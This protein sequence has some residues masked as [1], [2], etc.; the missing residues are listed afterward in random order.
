MAHPICFLLDPDIEIFFLLV[1][2]AG[3][4]DTDEAVQVFQSVYEERGVPFYH[5]WILDGDYEREAAKSAV[6]QAIKKDITFTAVWCLSDTM[7]MGAYEAFYECGLTIPHDV[8]VIGTNDSFFARHM[9]PA[10]TTLR[11]RVF[12]AG[13]EAAVSLLKTIETGK[14]GRKIFLESELILRASVK[15]LSNQHDY[16]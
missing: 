5:E 16:K 11:R 2:K 15:V 1:E 7:A 14:A 13:R 10:L 4:L 12:D 3:S 8:S 6:L 9:S